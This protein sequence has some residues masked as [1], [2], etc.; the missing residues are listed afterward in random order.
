MPA[1][2]QRAPTH[3]VIPSA[4]DEERSEADRGAA[5]LSPSPSSSVPSDPS[6]LIRGESSP[7]APPPA[8]VIIPNWNGLRLLR[9]CLDALRCQTLPGCEVIVVENASTDGSR[10]ALAAEYP[11]VRVLAQERNLG[12]AAGC[13]VGI[14]AARGRAIVLLNNDV[15][16]AP[17]WLAELTAALERHPEAGAVASR[18][19][20]HADR[21]VL[22]G[23]GDL[24]RVDGTPDSRGVWQPYG[25]PYDREAEVFGASG[26]A[27]AY[28]REM[29]EEIGPFEERFFMWCEDVDLAWRA[30]L[31][32]WAAVY[33]PR[34][35]CY[36][37]GSATGGGALSSYYVGRNTIWVIARNYPGGLLR[38][39]ARAVLG[40][41]W[42]IARDA[43]RA[44]RGA[45]ARARL[46][47][48]LVGLF[49]AWRW[50]GHRRRLLARR[51]A[52]DAAIEAV[53]D[54]VVERE[55][56]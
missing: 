43:L 28:R 26:G 15:E 47:G 51:R 44:W 8:S 54:P 48:Q 24:Y 25:P 11:E 19:M 37:H 10:E 50:I 5:R 32:G 41:Q 29:L 30:R 16:V 31:A 1:P 12:F 13:N 36:H 55:S 40:A 42:R 4:Q 9:P 52:D 33:A 7:S 6:V 17:D 22:N 56:P 2:A 18:M 49:T 53:L 38:K 3:P 21:D 39:H 46:R 35:V 20:S 23:A 34:A 27:V 45:A 14:R